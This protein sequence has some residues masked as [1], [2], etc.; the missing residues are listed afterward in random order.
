[1]SLCVSFFRPSFLVYLISRIE[2]FLLQETSNSHQRSGTVLLHTSLHCNE[3]QPIV[4]CVGSVE[5]MRKVWQSHF[6]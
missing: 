3:R 6:F 2:T 1:M 4:C 5:I